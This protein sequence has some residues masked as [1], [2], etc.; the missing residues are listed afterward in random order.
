MKTAKKISRSQGIY[1]R[2]LVLRRVFNAPRAKVYKMW[3]DQKK[4]A[5]WWGPHGFTCPVCQLDAR[6]GGKIKVDMRAPDGKIYPMTG[7][8]NKINEPSLLVFTTFA[9]I[10]GG[11]RPDFEVLNI[12]EFTEKNG[13]TAITLT[14]KVLKSGKALSEAAKVALSGM[15]EGWSQSLEKLSGALK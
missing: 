7:V 12:V 1:E 10:G 13:K 11:K 14:A 2:E 3:V 5:N 4:L 8:F 6:E 9:F 15:E